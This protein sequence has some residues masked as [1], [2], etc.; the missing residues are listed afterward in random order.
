MQEA[1]LEAAIREANR[2]FSRGYRLEKAPPASPEAESTSD[3]GEDP[4]ESVEL[5]DW[6]P[7]SLDSERRFA[8]PHA[9]L[10]QFL[11]RKVRTPKGPGILLQVFVDRV[12]VLLDSQSSLLSVFHSGEIE[13]VSPK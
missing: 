13:P 8:Q 1:E 3:T 10:F 12:A 11:G 5:G 9:K 2:I 6:P 7:E 4:R